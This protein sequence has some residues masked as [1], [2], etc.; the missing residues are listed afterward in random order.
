MVHVPNIHKEVHVIT[1]L[2]DLNISPTAQ[3]KGLVT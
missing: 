1:I 2:I 3:E